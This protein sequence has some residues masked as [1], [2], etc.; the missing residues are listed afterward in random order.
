MSLCFV[1]PPNLPKKAQAQ[2][3]Y[4]IQNYEKNDISFNAGV[5]SRDIQQLRFKEITYQDIRDTLQ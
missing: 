4:N 5:H 1:R 3:K 2:D